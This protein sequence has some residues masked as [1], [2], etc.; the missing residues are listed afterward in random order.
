MAN[1][2]Q[3]TVQI[4]AQTVPADRECVTRLTDIL[5]GIQDFTTI[6]GLAG[7]NG[8]ALPTQDIIGSQALALAQQNQAQISVINAGL[9]AYQSSNGYITV[10]TGDSS[11]PVVFQTQM[12]ADIYMVTI[13]LQGVGTHPGAYYA[14]NVQKGTMS[15]QGFTIWFD[16]LPAGWSFCWK[17]EVFPSATG[18]A[19]VIANFSPTSGPVGTSV[20][21]TGSGF[22]GATAVDFGGTPAAFTT[23]SDS[24]ITA[25]V[26]TGSSTGAINVTTSQG[27]GQSTTSFTVT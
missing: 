13:T 22:T 23:N 9:L 3:N 2:A 26:A 14:W 27:S 6:N 10:P 1:N 12:S 11:Y 19:V 25:I 4:V 7:Q 8:Q 20:V 5:Q 18:N 21:I 17:A 15:S 24:Q 16:N